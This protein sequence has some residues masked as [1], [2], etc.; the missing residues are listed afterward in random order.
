[1]PTKRS[2]I[3]YYVFGGLAV[4]FGLFMFWAMSDIPLPK[5]A[6]KEGNM[7]HIDISEDAADEI[8]KKEG[9]F[10]VPESFNPRVFESG[11]AFYF[12]FP[13][14]TPYTGNDFPLPRDQIRVV[15][16][17]HKKTSALPSE[18]ILRETQPKGGLLKQIPYLVDSKDGVEI[19][20]YDYGRAGERS[21]GSYFKF[22]TKEGSNI[23]VGD[24]G[25]W[26]RD[27]EINRKLSPH[28]ALFSMPPKN[29]VRDSKH[30]IEDVTAVDYAVVKLV[31][32][33]QP[34]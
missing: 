32:S 30:F 24:A 1:M 25:D 16:T 3:S 10:V 7:I 5:N 22:V 23:L 12:K 11:F 14:G 8:E 19:Y 9:L 15:I 17:H 27:Y 13:D 33:F 26:S 6:K 4:L 28:V 34:K 31:Q 29:L 18:Y 21:I 2:N 20:Q